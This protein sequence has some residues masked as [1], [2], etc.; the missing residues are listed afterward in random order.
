MIAY[1][2]IICVY[3]ILFYKYF[4]GRQENYLNGERLGSYENE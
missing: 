2:T 4:K 1:E 3:V